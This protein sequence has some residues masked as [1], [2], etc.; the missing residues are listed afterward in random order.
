M[1]HGKEADVADWKR[2]GAGDGGV[3]IAQRAARVDPQTQFLAN[4]SAMRTSLGAD[5]EVTGRLSFNAPTRIDGKLNGDVKCTDL[6]VVGES[7]V[8]EGSV[9]ASELIV[10]GTVFG[11]VRGA[12][13]VEVGPRGRIGGTVETHTLA[14]REGGRLDA[15]C[16]V[17]TPRADVHFLDR[18]RTGTAS[19]QAEIDD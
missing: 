9:R 1:T 10:L 3:A 16:R 2:D 12:Q 4:T 11:D 8:I 5:A 13:R 7:G 6:L 17:M 14:V 18:H 15:T 19:K